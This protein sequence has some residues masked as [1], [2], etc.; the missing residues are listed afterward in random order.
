M[1]ENILKRMIFVQFVRFCLIGVLNTLITFIAYS[2]LV[3]FGV[4]YLIANFVGFILGVINSFYWNNR[5]VFAN[6]GSEKRK[7]IHTFL[8]TI[9]ANS[10]TGI[11]LVSI[12]LIIFVEHFHFSRY[13][14]QI[15]GIIICVPVNFMINKYW[16]YRNNNIVNFLTAYKWRNH[17]K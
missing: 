14:A 2:I 17:N 16:A 3:Y 6:T 4:I 9:I 11:F 1:V 8:K 10:F 13:V 12:L 7:L 5:Y 15:I